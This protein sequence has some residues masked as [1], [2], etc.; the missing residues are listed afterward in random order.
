MTIR[1]GTI[2][3]LS[4]ALSALAAPGLARAEGDAKP[5]FDGST[6]KGWI[7]T[8]GKPLPAKFV[9]EGGINPHGTGSYIV[10]YEEKLGDF[11]VDF[12]YKLSK[13]CNSG[14]FFR[15]N[16]LKDPVYSGIEIAID[17]TTGTG[18][19][20]S[21]AFYDLVRPSTNAQKPAGE[22]NHMTVTAKGPEVSVAINGVE[23]SRINLDEWN[24]PGKRPDGSNHKFE[25]VAIGKLG[26]TGYFGFQDHGQ[27]CWYKNI[28]LRKP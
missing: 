27:D 6:P 23:V 11:V 18:Y 26:R 19:H 28:T 5:I 7:L 4:L 1:K 16:D 24:E 3:A 2:L 25:K 13:G 17:D 10:V 22:W 21:G 9:Q 12:D 8:D 15:V 20:D 14:V